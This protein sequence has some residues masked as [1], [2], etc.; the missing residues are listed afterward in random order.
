M[1]PCTY[2]CSDYYDYSVLFS[3][4][5]RTNDYA[6][7][8]CHGMPHHRIAVWGISQGI[9]GLGHNKDSME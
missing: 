2:P 9:L 3:A 5:V 8:L 6:Y 1:Y 4:R 7:S